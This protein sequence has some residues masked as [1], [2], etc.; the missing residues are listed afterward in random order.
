MVWTAQADG[1][2][3]VV[4]NAA[5]QTAYSAVSGYV[6][7]EPSTDNG[8]D[9]LTVVK[10]LQK[11]GIS[12]YKIGAFMAINQPMPLGGPLA[13]LLQVIN[14]FGGAYIGL[15]MP[16]SAQAQSYPGGTWRVPSTGPQGNGQPGSWGGHAV[17]ARGYNKYGLIVPTWNFEVLVTW[18]FLA[19]YCDEAYAILSPEW[20]QK[21]KVAPSGFNLAAM[22]NALEGVQLA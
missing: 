8:A 14:L 15:A 11:T 19:Y 21:D 4:S 22:Q 20:L 6:P 1:T 17:I 10:Y 16:V 9:M 5:I 3:I 12:G 2:P 7:G 18:N 13:E